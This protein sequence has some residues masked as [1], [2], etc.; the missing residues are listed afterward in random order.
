M[1]DTQK[2]EPEVSKDTSTPEQSV[3]VDLNKL[4]ANAKSAAKG[5]HWKRL[6][7]GRIDRQNYLYGAVGSIVLALLLALIPFIR[8]LVGIVLLLLGFGMTVRRLHDID[9]TGWASLL[10]FIPFIGVLE[11]VYLCWKLGNVSTN[12][13]GPTPDPKREMFHAILNT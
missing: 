2:Q 9:Q 11:V 10:L 7:S 3:Q 1:N 12:S 8:M 4:Y 6:F 5:L 13:Y